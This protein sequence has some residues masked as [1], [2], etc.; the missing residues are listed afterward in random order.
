MHQPGLEQVQVQGQHGGL[1]GLFVGA[2]QVAV[3]AV[4]QVVVGGVPV[5]YDLEAVVVL[6]AQVGVGEVVADERRTHR[7]REFFDRAGGGMLGSPAGE[8]PQDV[9][10]FGWSAEAAPGSATSRP[11]RPSA[12]TG[13]PSRRSSAGAAG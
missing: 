3:L 6:A 12:G 2:G 4:E 13:V 5:L 10:G 1:L 9:F 11:G 8:A 7:P